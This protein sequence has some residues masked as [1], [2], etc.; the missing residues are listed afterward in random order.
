MRNKAKTLVKDPFI[1]MIA[2]VVLVPAGLVVLGITRQ[3]QSQSAVQNVLNEASSQTDVSPSPSSNT[4]AATPQPI[5]QAEQPA[6]V[7]EKQS[8]LV[9]ALPA[10]CDQAKKQDAEANRT[11]LIS[12]ENAKH[13]G[14]VARAIIPGLS[15]RYLEEEAARHQAALVVIE[16]AYRTAVVAANC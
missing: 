12:K 15:T 10:V 1:V 11:S 16:D 7:A 14:L 9:A 3:G 6:V 5:T 4:R 8:T 2:F 13:D